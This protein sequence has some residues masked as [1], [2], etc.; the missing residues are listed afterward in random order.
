MNDPWSPP[1][2]DVPAGASRVLFLAFAVA[3]GLFA[4]LVLVASFDSEMRGP[5]WVI[6]GPLAA[7]ALG[8]AALVR[9]RAHAR[10][11]TI[12][13]E[14]IVEHDRGHTTSLRYDQIDAIQLKTWDLRGAHVAG[15]GVVGAI[16]TAAIR[17]AANAEHTALPYDAAQVYVTLRAGDRTI[18]LKKWDKSWLPAYEQ[19][20]A[21]VEPRLLAVARGE[22]ARAGA[23]EFGPVRVRA[24]EIAIKNKSVPMGELE[25]IDVSALQ[26]AFR[27]RGKRL[28]AATVPTSKVPNLHVLLDLV[29]DRS[30]PSA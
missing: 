12:H 20:R 11:I 4:G 6:A 7:I 28:P 2:L 10:R 13:E 21:R 22:L 24:D 23:V 8:V 16:T 26:I 30:R 3:G 17:T 27:R 15:G 18:V 1:V 25:R 14:G 19:I 5:A 9:K 29:G